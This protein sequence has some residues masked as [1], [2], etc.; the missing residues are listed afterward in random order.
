M[1]P[2]KTA[3]GAEALKHFKV[4]EG[5]PPAY[6]KVKRMVVPAAL[7][8]VRLK[9]GRAVFFSKYSSVD[10]YSSVC[11]VVFPTRSAG[12]I[13]MSFP[14]LRQ[15]ARSRVQLT[16]SRRRPLWYPTSLCLFADFFQKLHAQAVKNT[17][18][19]TAEVN[20]ALQ[21]KGF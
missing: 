6:E 2:H 9:P 4:F 13:R 16:T 5:I 14:L 18:A 10:G 20:A 15:S 21:A 8:I 3:R 11:L 7:R 17:V 1:L 12:S 19:A